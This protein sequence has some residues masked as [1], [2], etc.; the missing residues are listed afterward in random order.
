MIAARLAPLALA[1]ALVLALAP[2]RGGAAAAYPPGRAVVLVADSVLYAAW[3]AADGARPGRRALLRDA[4]GAVL[5]TLTVSWVREAIAA[6]PLSPDRARAAPGLRLEP[7]DDTAGEVAVRGHLRVP[8]GAG[9]ETLDPLYVTTLAEKQVATQLFTGLVRLDSTLAPRP[10]LAASWSVE[11]ARHVFRLRPDASFHAGRAVRAIDVQA[12]LERAL[13]PAAAAPRVEELARAIAGGVAYHTGRAPDLAGVRVI[14]SLT[15][16]ISAAGR[17]SGLLAELAAPAAFVVPAG[18]RPAPMGEAELRAAQS[19]P[20]RLA[21]MSERSISLV[22]APGRAGG[23]ASLDL[24]VL[25]SPSEAAIE[26]ELGRLDLVSPP[27][28]IARRILAGPGPRPDEVRIEEAATYYLGFDTRRPFVSDRGRRRALAALIDRALAVRVLVPGRGRL[29]HGL[30]P[31]IFGVEAPP[32]SAW[33]MPRAEAERRARGN[34]GG[35]APA[36][37]FWVPAG[38]EVGMRLAEFV[39]SAW[40]RAGLQVT[41]VERPWPA[42]QRGIAEGKA[43]AFYWSWFADGPDPV[44]FVASMVESSRRGAGGN[45]TQYSSRAV[46]RAIGEARAAASDRAA[47]A[48]LRRAERLA[49][50]DAPLVPLFHSVNVTLVRPGVSGVVLDPLGTPRYDAVEVR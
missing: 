3:S 34:F 14:D 1:L 31:P 6:L 4:S 10:V 39:A 26:F 45:R 30:L 13:A 40:R 2:A 9:P 28:A 47:T 21:G 38:S 50:A 16:E 35:A 22:A 25:P 7:L 11:G 23:P 24:L 5:D 8:L 32:E 29:A 48:A 36:L 46:D 43:D 17:R 20:F 42:F 27:E 15:V 44:A 33:I 41:I 19:G 18:T 49:L 12:T 37:S